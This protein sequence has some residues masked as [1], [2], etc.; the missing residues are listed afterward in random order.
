[1]WHFYHETLR[2]VGYAKLLLFPSYG[3]CGMFFCDDVYNK[4]EGI[5]NAVCFEI[6]P[7]HDDLMSCVWCG[8]IIWVAWRSLLLQIL[9]SV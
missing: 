8:C 6:G 4:N 5:C 9:G 1:M 3:G 2:S 7:V